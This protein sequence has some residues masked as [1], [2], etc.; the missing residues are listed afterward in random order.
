MLTIPSKMIV[1]SCPVI[2]AKSVACYSLSFSHVF[3]SELWHPAPQVWPQATLIFFFFHRSSVPSVSLNLW[4]IHA[5]RGPLLAPRNVH[6]RASN[7]ILYVS[8]RPV[9]ALPQHPGVFAWMSATGCQTFRSLARDSSC[10][11]EACSCPLDSTWS[12]TTG[13]TKPIRSEQSR[14]SVKLQAGS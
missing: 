10:I 2:S 11:F 1:L 8:G 4:A 3:I 14:G 5:L 13:C 9:S 6:M 12:S 7:P